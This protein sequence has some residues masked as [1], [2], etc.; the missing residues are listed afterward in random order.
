[1]KKRK[2]LSILL[3]A[4]FFLQLSPL[5]IG[6]V[7][8]DE[9]ETG[10]FIAEESVG[11]A[12]LANEDALT[13]ENE[14]S[15]EFSAPL[16]N[17]TENLQTE[18]S[19]FGT[20]DDPVSRDIVLIFD[21]SG[22]MSGNPLTQAKKAA[23]NFCQQ[24]LSDGTHDVRVAVAAF[25]S[26][27]SL[28]GF[29]NDLTDLT[30]FINGLS[31]GGGT[32]LTSA[33]NKVQQLIDSEQR[34]DSKISIVTLSDGDPNSMS[35][36]KTAADKLMAKYDMYSVGF[37]HSLSGSSKTRCA[38]FLKS[39]QN[40]GYYEVVDGDLLEIE[41]GSIA[42]NIMSDKTIKFGA[43]KIERSVSVKWGKGLFYDAADKEYDADLALVSAA[44]SSAIYDGGKERG[45]YINKALEELGF[46]EHLPL[47]VDQ[48]G[49][50]D[51]FRHTIGHQ[52]MTDKNGNS[53]NLIVVVLRGTEGFADGLANLNVFLGADAEGYHR[54]F[55]AYAEKAHETLTTYLSGKGLN[56]NEPS[57][58]T[59]KYLIV[60]HSLGA[61]AANILGKYLIAGRS[62]DVED[63]LRQNVI[64]ELSSEANTY[65]YTIASPNMV[66]PKE[67]AP[68]ATIPNLKNIYNV[69]NPFD[70]VTGLP[71][72]GRKLGTTLALPTEEKVTGTSTTA[73]EFET[74]LAG[75]GYVAVIP[76]LEDPG[77]FKQRDA[78]DFNFTKKYKQKGADD[79]TART[80]TELYTELKSEYV[81]WVKS[82][83]YFGQFVTEYKK[84][85]GSGTSDI[86]A[87]NAIDDH[88]Y[89]A[90]VAWIKSKPQLYEETT[91]GEYDLYT[92]RYIKIS[93]KC[94]VDV[95]V[96]DAYGVLAGQ[97][98]NN[99]VDETVVTSRDVLVQ[100]DG[101]DKY[102]YLLSE[103]NDDY[104]V[105]LTGTDDGSMEY[106]IEEISLLDGKLLGQKV[107]TNVALSTGKQMIS[108]VGGATETLKSRL[109]TFD[110]D[111]NLVK[112]IATDGTEKAVSSGTSSSGG[113]GGGGGGGSSSDAN[114]TEIPKATEDKAQIEPLETP[115]D[116]WTNPF[117]DVSEADWFFGDVKYAV[118]NGLFA[119]TSADTFSPN[120]PMTRGMLVT[121]LGRLYGADAGA[122]SASSFSDV[123]AGQYYAPYIEWA[124][125]AGIVS[126][127]GDNRFA[128]DVS[129]SRQD[130]AALLMRYANFSQKQFP[131]TR[132]FVTFADDAQI[133]DYAKNSVRSLYNGGIISGKPNN[134]FDPRGSATRAEVAAMM[135]RFIE[136]AK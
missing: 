25:G 40:K 99:V 88:D 94:P 93:I 20:A 122:Y 89:Q 98:V 63:I 26:S 18:L 115:S 136:A 103:S 67:V 1:M 111:D 12:A 128:P 92:S 44:L 113:G 36:A 38:D 4:V 118:A 129:I 76:K 77:Q 49:Q 96:Y 90:Y 101:D 124:Q 117:R 27:V 13:D 123:E 71:P 60:G 81:E 2:I 125:Q 116:S 43:N 85:M 75:K 3:T 91:P 56:E 69:V 9:N 109:F 24:L 11:D 78:Q 133:A 72:F 23:I 65:V 39:V 21:R 73:F 47:P 34:A 87:V 32:D 37:L 79:S 53:Y 5:G 107:F 114:S 132:Q 105:L 110:E 66:A 14:R 54:G 74:F 80:R 134:V 106:S 19:L 31:D 131:A 82:K 45:Y 22:S 61:A 70:T 100:V 57:T 58:R 130:L 17:K 86:D 108:T 126:G 28:R 35:T 121:V 52:V 62:P 29:T 10:G 102:L 7:W 48:T 127:V 30:N 15:D 84:I 95:S 59:N 135:H 50:P 68:L 55:S 119:G 51:N 42:E 6:S 97:V 33:Y 64:Q 8:A 112:E 104:T 46:T 16:D 41:L 83:P 120:V